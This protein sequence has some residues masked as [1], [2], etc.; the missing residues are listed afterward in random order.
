[1]PVTA[2]LASTASIRV[3]EAWLEGALLSSRGP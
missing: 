1:V 3:A 2:A